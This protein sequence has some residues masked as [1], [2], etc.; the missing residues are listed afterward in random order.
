MSNQNEG[1]SYPSPRRRRLRFPPGRRTRHF[2]PDH[3]SSPSRPA[4]AP[5][6]P[7]PAARRHNHR[8]HLMAGI[9]YQLHTM[10]RVG[11]RR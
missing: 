6:G 10:T 9:R 11:I 4:P 7:P 8:V 1:V 3:P 2:Y 5:L